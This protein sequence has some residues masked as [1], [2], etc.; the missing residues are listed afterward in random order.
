MGRSAQSHHGLV[1]A[2]RE[3]REV[4]VHRKE[5][6]LLVAGARRDEEEVAPLRVADEVLA[7]VEHPAAGVLSRGGPDGLCIRTRAR[8]GDRQA[9]RALAPDRRLQPPLD[10]FPF[11]SQQRVV[12]VA[13]GATHEEVGAVAELFFAQHRVDRAQ[14]TP[15]EL[16]RQL[17]GPPRAPWC[18]RLPSRGG[19]PPGR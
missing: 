7:A 2:E 9:A 12:H 14:S 16:R 6:D 17:A 11:A 13:E 8:F 4:L 10:L 15:T 19:W 18:R 5:R 1:L 3:T